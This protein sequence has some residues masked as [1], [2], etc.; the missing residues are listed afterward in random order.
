M[1]TRGVILCTI[2][3][4]IAA[5][6]GFW[7]S[8]TNET[9]F[10]RVTR[11][12]AIRVGY[13]TEMPFAYRENGHITGEAPE[14]VRAVLD[15]MGIGKITWTHTEFGLLI[16]NLRAGRFDIIAA[17]M[18]VTPERAEQV[19][20]SHPSV[21]VTSALLVETGN[22]LQLHSFGDIARSD[23]AI[24]AA[25]A[26]TLEL[27]AARDAGVPSDRILTF[28]N[29]ELAAEAVSSGLAQALA[30]TGP[31]IRIFAKTMTGLEQATPF[32]DRTEIAGCTAFAFR[33]QDRELLRRFD[34]T[35]QAFLGSENHLSQVG[36]FGVTAKNLPADDVHF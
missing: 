10:D 8:K 13:A 31:T 7:V 14:V 35:L 22:P 9:T 2:V 33:L 29:G 4:V 25:V 24:L 26:E 36:P 34:Q 15:R 12:N 23:R 6:A 30:L 17:G 11:A 16:P 21:C 32:H 3:L 27:A 20:F 28:A 5:T 19:A 18:Y 1:R